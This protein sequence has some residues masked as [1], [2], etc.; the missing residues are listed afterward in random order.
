MI[1]AVLNSR[2]KGFE[3]GLINIV[4]IV[5]ALFVFGILV[6]YGINFLDWGLMQ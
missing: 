1:A 3:G 6:V 2:M 4:A 5:I